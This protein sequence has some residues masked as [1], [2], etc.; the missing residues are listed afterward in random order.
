M[1]HLPTLFRHEL[2]VLLVAPSTYVAG[3]LALF[4]MGFF[5]FYVVI[6]TAVREQE[7]PPSELFFGTFWIPV[8]LIVPMLT[9]RS[10]A[11]ERRLGTLQTLMTTPVSAAEVVT[12]KF[13]AAYTFYI[14]LWAC[15]GAYPL[16]AASVL[17]R[18]TAGHVLLEPGPLLGGY[19]F[20][21]L[22]GTLFVA[23]G[24]FSSS[25]TRSQ[26]VAGMLSFSVIFLLIVGVL[27][28][29]AVGSNMEALPLLT[30]E[31]LGY[32]QIFEHFEDFTRGVIDT[33]PVVYYLSGTVLVLALSTLVVESRA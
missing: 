28:V 30:D 15:A 31:G 20:V 21:C 4:I 3:V 13:L 14:V 16:I 32:I 23:V 1:K 25:L 24:I 29:K 33:R 19:A 26:L 11:E 8:L 10:I 2:R 5:Y 12:S 22:T 9:M 6:E 17:G 18:E 27:A 7:T